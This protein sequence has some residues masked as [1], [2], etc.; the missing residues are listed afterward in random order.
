M[1]KL[2]IQAE[3]NVTK[4]VLEFPRTAE[5]TDPYDEHSFMLRLKHGHWGCGAQTE[6]R[7]NK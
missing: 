5:K 2:M 4:T 6:M 1:K 7:E 3:R